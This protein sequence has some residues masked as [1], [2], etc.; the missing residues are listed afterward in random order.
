MRKHGN[1]LRNYGEVVEL[2]CKAVETVASVVNSIISNNAFCLG[3]EDG[4][5]LIID[6]H[7]N[8][9][10]AFKGG[11]LRREVRSITGENSFN[12]VDGRINVFF[13]LFENAVGI[14]VVRFVENADFGKTKGVYIFCSN[15]TLVTVC[16]AHLISVVE[17]RNCVAGGRRSK[18]ENIVFNRK[19]FEFKT[20]S[21]GYGTKRNLH[22]AFEHGSIVCSNFGCIVGIVGCDE[23]EHNAVK[24]ACCV[25]FINCHLCGVCNSNAINCCCTGKGSGNTKD[26]FG[27]VFGVV[28]TAGTCGK[29]K[30]HNKSHN[31]CN[32]FFEI[33]FHLKSLFS[34]I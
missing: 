25:D 31:R 12:N 34:T 11:D 6:R 9:G 18:E 24:A 2:T 1:F 27:V 15:F 8:E 19:L 23:F 4:S 30:H 7:E 26:K 29:G 17:F 22:A 32:N 20:G 16:K 14:S 3:H 5:R 13:E 10:A 28:S 21:G 33:G